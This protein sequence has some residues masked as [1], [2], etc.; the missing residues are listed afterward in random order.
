[1]VWFD[2][3]RFGDFI[4]SLMDSIHFSIDSDGSVY[5]SR[6]DEAGEDVPEHEDEE[7][8]P[9]FFFFFDIMVGALAFN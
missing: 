5:L 6:D 9:N 1:M 7:R 8:Q 4:T 2:L 3:V